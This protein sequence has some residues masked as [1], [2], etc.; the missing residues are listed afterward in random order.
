[1]ADSP[2]PRR[3]QLLAALPDAEWQRW[4]P[5]LADALGARRDCVT[6]SAFKLE[7][8]GLIQYARN[9]ITVLDRPGLEKR[10]CECAGT[11]RREYA[12]LLPKGF[13]A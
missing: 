3:N 11:V 10:A 7:R 12:R 9:G 1:M 13:T 6:E 2:D 5:Q 8:A 4:Q